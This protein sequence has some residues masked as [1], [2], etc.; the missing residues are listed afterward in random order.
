[1]TVVMGCSAVGV[2]ENDE[3]P[4]SV[5]LP[6]SVHV[7][8]LLGFEG[9]KSNAHGTLAIE[10]DCL[11]LY[12]GGMRAAQVKLASVRAVSLGE[13]SKQVGG[14]PMTLGKAATPYGGGRVISLFAH[15]KYD[16]LAV[17]YSDVDGGAH[18]AIF[19]LPIGQGEVLK[20]ELVAKGARAGGNDA[21]N[22][23]EVRNE[24]K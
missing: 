4:A 18:G 22:S 15:K 11:V 8:H 9:V 14:L 17:E 23:A 6:F 5:I 16:T 2:A 7:T 21:Q 19:Q 13:E 1:M 12:T 3:K 20:N 10:D 24:S